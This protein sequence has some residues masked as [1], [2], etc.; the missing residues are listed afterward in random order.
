[1]LDKIKFGQ[2]DL[3][4][5]RV[6]LG[7]VKFGRN[8]GVRYPHAYTLPTDKE[9]RELLAYAADLGINL[10]DTAP[11]YGHSEERLGKALKNQRHSW[12][13]GTKVGE[14]F[15]D[16]QSH[17]DFSTQGVTNSINRSL[18]LLQ[19]DY[20]DYV[21]V[22]SDGNDEAIINETT[23]FTDLHQLKQVGKIRA[24][25]MSTKT[26]AGG[27]LA[28]ERSD[29]VMVTYNPIQAEELPVIEY[30]AKNNKAIL[31]K[32]AFASGHLQ[33]FTS[34]NPIADVMDFIFAT[35]GVSSIILGTLNP[36]HLQ[37]NVE[38]AVRAIAK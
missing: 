25:G 11:A 13:L 16:G 24:F 27:I 5:S 2:T 18:Q 8:E 4:I 12:V 30:A 9:I 26:V 7:T 34:E 10:L 17:F 29:A 38:H 14:E 6:G 15:N 3:S 20:L 23:I 21:L 1:M 37:T 33:N 19:T 31:I 28:A 35:P 32:K 22:H 36:K